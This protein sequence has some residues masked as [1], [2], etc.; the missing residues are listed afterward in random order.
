MKRAIYDTRV[1]NAASCHIFRQS[2]VTHLLENGQDI[3]RVQELLGHRDV[4][5]A[6]IYT[7]VLNKLRLA[8]RSPL[9]LD[10]SRQNR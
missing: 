6:R 4:S 3:R 2:F 10:Q 9:S 8:I 5:T 1:P 7:H